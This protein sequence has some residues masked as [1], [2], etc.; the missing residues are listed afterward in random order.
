MDGVFLGLVLLISGAAAVTVPPPTNVSVSCHNLKVTVD[1]TYSREEPETSFRINVT[2]ETGHETKM[3]PYE[4]KD[5]QYDLSHY[6]WE[7]EDHYMDNFF[8]TVKAVRGGNHS[9]PVQSEMFSFNSLKTT[10]I[11]CELEFPPPRL[12]KE[13]SRIM[14]S[15]RNPLHYYKKLKEAKKAEGAHIKYSFT[16]AGAE[17]TED[18]DFVCG[19][20]DEDCRRDVSSDSQEEKCV[21]LKG[22]L[23]SDRDL[24][25]VTFKPTGRFCFTPPDYTL[26]ITLAVLLSIV[27][28]IIAVL[29]ILVWKVKAWTMKTPTPNVLIPEDPT[30]D[31]PLKRFHEPHLL[32]SP[33]L[34]PTDDK[35]EITVNT[36]EDGYPEERSISTEELVGHDDNNEGYN[37]E[38]GLSECS[39]GGLDTDDNSDDL[40]KT[41]SSS[42]SMDEEE[43]EE[44]INPYTFPKFPTDG[45]QIY[46]KR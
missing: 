8:V 3:T 36:E 7:S 42:I 27:A 14:L 28:F 29:A 40:M 44:E 38:G 9:V 6:I 16:L 11:K 46:H 2:N 45:G 12:L 18:R 25:Y 1:W 32:I 34:I 41:Q 22:K 17:A 19:E 4:T 39:S 30:E 37:M 13:E 21:T 26:T 10:K 43:M 31:S 20:E 35:M 24:R 33:V 5:H 15:F 23:Y